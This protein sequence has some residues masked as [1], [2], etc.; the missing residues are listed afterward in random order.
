M[1]D[2]AELEKEYNTYEHGKSRLEG[3]R[4]AIKEADRIGN[5]SYMIHFRLELNRESAIF[6][7]RLDMLLN[8]PE[9]LALEDRYPNTPLPTNS[10]S[11]NKSTENVLWQYKWILCSCQD[12]YQ[13][14]LSDSLKFFE[15]Y[16]KRSAAM[17]YNERS[18]YNYLSFF[19]WPIDPEYA[20]ECRLNTERLPRDLNADCQACERNQDIEFLLWQGRPELAEKLARDIDS[21]KLTCH[22]ERRRAWLELKTNYLNYHLRRGEYEQAKSYCR[23][24]DRF[25]DE[26]DQSKRLAAC[27]HAYAHTDLGKA[28]NLFKLHWREWQEWRCPAASFGIDLNISEFFKELLEQKEEAA[29]KISFE[30]GFPLYCPEQQYQIGELYQFYYGRARAVAEKLDSRNG[31]DYY[32][33]A[34]GSGAV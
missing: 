25:K 27:I 3:I 24:I 18:Y 12:F 2:L 28:L 19:Y 20:S 34:L 16:K 31:T 21:Y 26:E 10:L 23:Q 17:G 33:M 5:V 6:G 15:D 9:L 32:K 30:P 13:I 8:F 22:G 14:S 7:D 4:Q 1:Y 29:I 11:Y